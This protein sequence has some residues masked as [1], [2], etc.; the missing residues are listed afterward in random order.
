[1]KGELAEG[2][3][4]LFQRIADRDEADVGE[5]RGEGPGDGFFLAGRG[6]DGGKEGGRIIVE[7]AGREGG[8]EVDAALPGIVAEAGNGG[9]HVFAE[10]G[11]GER[12]A[13]IDAEAVAKALVEAD[14]GGTGIVFRPPFAR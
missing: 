7:H 10:N 5:L 2:V 14:K 9:G 11:E 6:G 13:E 4:H 8:E 1:R 12:I 3:G